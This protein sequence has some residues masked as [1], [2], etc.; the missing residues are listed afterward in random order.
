MG[1][2]RG[3]SGLMEPLRFGKTEYEF[4]WSRLDPFQPQLVNLV[5]LIFI[6]FSFL[7]PVDPSDCPGA[8]WLGQP[9]PG[10]ALGWTLEAPKSV[11]EQHAITFRIFGTRHRS[12]G[13][14]LKWCQELC[15]GAH[16]PHAPGARM[17]VVTQTPSNNMFINIPFISI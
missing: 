1:S 9:R 13:S 11:L 12:H 15:L 2:G 7:A 5:K 6:F 3:I 4:I 14:H 10:L 8:L 17:T 16:L